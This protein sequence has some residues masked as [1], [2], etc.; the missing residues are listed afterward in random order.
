[1]AEEEA[2]PAAPAGVLAHED[3]FPA[4]F[5][6]VDDIYHPKPPPAAEPAEV[7]EGEEP[8]PPAEPVPAPTFPSTA[9]AKFKAAVE[10]KAARDAMEEGGAGIVPEPLTEADLTYGELSFENLFEVL[11]KVKTVCKIFPAECCFVDCGSGL[12]KQVI[13]ASVLESFAKVVGYEI[14]EAY[15]TIAQLAVAKFKDEVME[16]MDESIPKCGD[17]SVVKANCIDELPGLCTPDGM[18]VLLCCFSPCFSEA[19]LAAICKAAENAKL[20]SVL[21][22]L[23]R[24][25]PDIDY[26]EP[27]LVEPLTCPW[28]DATLFIHEKIKMPPTEE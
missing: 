18:Q 15:D 19:H 9:E 5:A 24:D 4:R 12:G 26:W 10:K 27:V 21:V 22:T 25:S 23:T 28:G 3:A 11:N 8:P 17:I 6:I 7:P 2:A 13:G 16:G 20:G 14:L 1:M